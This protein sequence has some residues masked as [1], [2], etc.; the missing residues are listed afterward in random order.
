MQ[1]MNEERVEKFWEELLREEN[2]G[3]RVEYNSFFE[4]VL[5]IEVKSEGGF[6]E[7]VRDCLFR[8]SRSDVYSCVEERGL[9][10][11]QEE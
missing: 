1:N 5:S 3:G 6:F 7:E 9:G 4:Q 10:M 2:K 8:L 11:L